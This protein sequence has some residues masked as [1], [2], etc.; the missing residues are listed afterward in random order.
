MMALKR[1]LFLI[2]LFGLQACE[3]TDDVLKQPTGI[4]FNFGFTTNSALSGAVRFESGSLTLSRFSFEGERVQGDDAYFEKDFSDGLT[5]GIFNGDP[6]LNF[7]IPQGTY[8]R[9]EVEFELQ[10]AG[11]QSLELR[12]SFTDDDGESYPLVLKLGNYYYLEVEANRNQSGGEINLLDDQRYSA[13]IQLNPAH[14]FRELD[15]DDLEDAEII[16]YQGQPTL[17]ISEQHNEELW[18]EIIDDLDERLELVIR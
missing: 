18:D 17:L 6:A 2:L 5:I 4:D 15:E 3:T 11:S 12:G 13:E 16:N 10:S 9:I 1:L 7:E 8:N 14:W